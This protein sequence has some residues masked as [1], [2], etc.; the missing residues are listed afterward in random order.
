M[1]VVSVITTK[2]NH[3]DNIISKIAVDEEHLEKIFKQA[4]K[5]YIEKAKDLGVM[6]ESIKESLYDSCSVSNDSGYTI[7][8]VFS[9]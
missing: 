5:V 3:I 2:D 4:E 1:K 9:E 8:L 7:S 6:M